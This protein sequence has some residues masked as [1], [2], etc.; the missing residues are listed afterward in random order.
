M[1]VPAVPLA[2]LYDGCKQEIEGRGGEVNLRMP[3]RSIVFANG[4]I[5]GA[6]F[7]EGRREIADAYIFAVPHET[8]AKLLPEKIG[9]KPSRGWRIWTK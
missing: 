3:L 1:G 2:Q 7:D 8:L 4:A 5:Q 9:A 6:E